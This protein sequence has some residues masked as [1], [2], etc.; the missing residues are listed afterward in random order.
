M[1]ATAGGRIDAWCLADAGLRAGATA[2]WLT[3]GLSSQRT[4]DA[5]GPVGARA[6]P[7]PEESWCDPCTL[8]AGVVARIDAGLVGVVS[9][10]P[11]G[12]HPS[13]LAREVTTLDVLSGGRAALRLCWDAPEPVDAAAAGEHLV[14][15][16]AVCAA[17]VRGGV[18]AYDGRH[19]HVSGAR[20]RPAPVRAG[21]PPLLVSA[22]PELTAA[23]A[24]GDEAEAA[25]RSARAM[26]ALAD[27]VVCA[28]RP[29]AVAAWRAVVD[30]VAPEDRGDGQVPGLLCLLT[31]A[32]VHAGSLASDAARTVDA[33][34][35]GVVLRVPLSL[36]RALPDLAADVYAAWADGAT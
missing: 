28:A 15:A 31:A 20:N 19:F 26:S 14:D 8:A 22:P 30:G 2:V 12:R 33:G 21:G 4:P 1:P 23:L 29:E 9:P 10:L 35:E 6:W 16:M 27:A 17:M 34:A 3:G 5:E 13:V 11:A 24:G 7:D 32:E 36:A 18:P 25:R